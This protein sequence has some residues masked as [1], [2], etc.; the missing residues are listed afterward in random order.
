MNER[1]VN[2][3]ISDFN[4]EFNPFNFK[5][6]PEL[7]VGYENE[8]GDI[9]RSLD[10]GNN[11]SL[12]IGE[13]GA[14]KTNLLRWLNSKYSNNGHDVLYMPKPPSQESELLDYMVENLL[15]PSLFSRMFNSYSLY[16][17][18]DDLQQKIDS[19]TILIIDEGHESSLEV[20]K[21]VRT[22]IDQ[23][24]DLIAIISGLPSFLQFLQ[25]DIPSLHDRV[26]NVCRLDSLSRDETFKLIRRRI[27]LAGGS[28]I[29]PFN[30]DSIMKIYQLTDGFPRE[31]L[32]VCNQTV[33]DASRNDL[34]LIDEADV[35]H[36]E[37]TSENDKSSNKSEDSEPDINLTKKQKKIVDL[38]LEN[39][40]S[41]A[42]DVVSE[43][44]ISAYKSESHAVRSVN[45]ILKRLLDDGILDRKREGKSY[46]YYISEK[47]ESFFT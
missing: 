10:A 40:E 19:Q 34:S 23:V 44:D 20:L 17:I 30:Q 1:E 33:L 45:N 12:V 18:F 41:S 14:G 22:A 31:V 8:I 37:L 43:M 13:T 6:Y 21:W 28:G 9:L 27:E 46:V 39:S 4:W 35:V 16:T 42:S 3:W 32:R 29:E 36:P 15:S 26:S 11:L 38:I 24:D 47:A 25:S 2:E 7:M 5:I